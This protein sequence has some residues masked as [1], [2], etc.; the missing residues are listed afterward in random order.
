MLQGLDVF[1]RGVTALAGSYT[2]TLAQLTA[3][4]PAA[5]VPR[6]TPA[7][8]TDQGWRYSDG[9]S[10]LALGGGGGGTTY[11]PVD[12]A[13]GA[14]SNNLNPTGFNAGAAISQL[15]LSLSAGAA[16]ITGLDL[17]GAA[18]GQTIILINKDSTD[19]ITLVHASA[20]SS[21]AN[22]FACPGGNDLFISPFSAV[23]VARDEVAG[24]VRVLP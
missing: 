16:S 13:I 4:Y 24:L 14:S 1:G 10:W 12:A 19:G 5:T 15:R 20:S 17:S 6:G 2:Y 11:T 3:Q 9:S 23:A 7:Y 22:R 18:D 21:A 8:T